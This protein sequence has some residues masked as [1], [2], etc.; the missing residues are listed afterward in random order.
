MSVTATD[1]GGCP[2]LRERRLAAGL[3]Q[4]HLA[5]LADCSTATVRIVERGYWPSPAMRT[6]LA[7]ALGCSVAEIEP[8]KPVGR[9]SR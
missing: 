2:R 3:S 9:R 5:R 8:A 7:G 1:P 4:E 6:K